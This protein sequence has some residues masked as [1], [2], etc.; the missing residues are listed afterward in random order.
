MTMSQIIQ[1]QSIFYGGSL[2][3]LRHLICQLAGTIEPIEGEKKFKVFNNIEIT[4]EN[5]VV[6]LEVRGIAGFY[7]LRSLNFKSI[8]NK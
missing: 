2:S 6:T 4:I 3:V 5:K 8:R 7:Q 1:R